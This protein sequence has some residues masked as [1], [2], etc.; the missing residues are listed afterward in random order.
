MEVHDLRR[1]IFCGKR[2]YEFE[3]DNSWTDEHIIPEALGNQS[4]IIKDVCKFCNSNLG[5]YVDKYITDN[6]IIQMLR[7]QY[8]LKGQSNS[9]PNP[10]YEGRDEY[11]NRV[12]VD[13]NFQ[14]H[15]V[16]HLNVDGNHITGVASSSEEA[17]Q[18][19]R[20][21]LERMGLSNEDIETNLNQVRSIQPR[22]S[23]PEI[24]YRFQIEVNRIYMEALKIAYEFSYYY[25]GDSYSNDSRGQKIKAKLLEAINGELKESCGAIDG[26][27]VIKN[28]DHKIDPK[29]PQHLIRFYQV[30]NS[31]YVDVYLFM[32]TVFSCSV[33]VSEDASQ[34]DFMEK[35]IVLDVI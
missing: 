8:G 7:L 20:K 32:L 19:V 15:V 23:N 9:L 21:K 25:L 34:Y 3:A 33:L 12:R 26:V 10:F 4:L 22:V 5:T 18:I 17:V 14:P 29:K 6:M 27:T 13:N 1:C 24:Q 16:P 31:L 35:E 28:I 30:G 2:E 11:N